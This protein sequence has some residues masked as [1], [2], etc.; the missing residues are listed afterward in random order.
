MDQLTLVIGAALVFLFL[1]Y[2]LYLGAKSKT[3]EAL[4]QAQFVTQQN[5]LLTTELAQERQL[6][7][8]A[9]STHIEHQKQIA[10]LSSNLDHIQEKYTDLLENQGQNEERFLHLANKVIEAKTTQF[11]THHK[12]GIKEI[13]EPLKD[14]IKT[15]EDKVDQSNKENIDRHASLRSQI[16]QLKELNEKITQEAANL[17]KALKGDNKTQGNW[18]ELILESIL[19]KSGLAKG[20]EYSIQTSLKDHEG[21]VQRPDVI[22]SLPDGKKMIIDSKVSL[23]AYESL[24]VADNNEEREI[25]LTAHHRSVKN[26]IDG[27]S[28]KN[29]H[30]LYQIESPDFVLLFIPID[31]A[32]SAAVAKDSNIYGYAFDKHI[33]IVTPATLL[34][35]LKTVDTLWKNDKQHRNALEIAT[36]AGKMYDKLANLSEDLISI[37]NRLDQTKD[38]YQESMKKLVH[39]KGNLIGRA[40]KIKTLGAKANKSINEKLVSRVS[41]GG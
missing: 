26:H 16:F 22:L 10:T 9:N 12:A 34:A 21:K 25:A 38:A 30:D 13:L 37:G 40:Q 41:D 35:T 14:K 28:A 8:K 1:L 4:Q 17:T 24:V 7:T 20:R 3:K 36:E 23:K 15:F 2:T 18:G 32:F 31:T 29:Y 39:G 11:D 27:L 33:V 19:D 5:Q 6:V